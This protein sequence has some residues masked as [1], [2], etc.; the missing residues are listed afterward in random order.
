MHH[1]TESY[2]ATKHQLIENRLTRPDVSEHDLQM[3]VELLN[4]I[5][6]EMDFDTKRE[7]DQYRLIPVP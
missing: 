6:D 4:Q 1:L 3:L 2:M 7:A 5:W